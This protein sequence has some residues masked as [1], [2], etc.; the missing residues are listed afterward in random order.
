[1][2]EGGA[3]GAGGGTFR[4]NGASYGIP[5]PKVR[6]IAD[7]P[8]GGGGPCCIEPGPIPKGGPGV[9]GPRGDITGGITPGENMGGPWGERWFGT[10]ADIGCGAA[11]FVTTVTRGC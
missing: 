3:M 4:T 1:M 8:R 10:W 5:L 7:G 11:W 9:N 2:A 6:G